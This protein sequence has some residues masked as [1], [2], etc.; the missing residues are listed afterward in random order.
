MVRT[1]TSSWPSDD[2][3]YA[4]RVPSGDS[5]GRSSGWLAVDQAQRRPRCGRPPVGPTCRATPLVVAG[6][7]VHAR[8]VATPD[9]IACIERPA[10]ERL[11]RALR[12]VEQPQAAA[13]RRR[14]GART[15]LTRVRTERRAPRAA[16]GVFGDAHRRPRRHA[17]AMERQAAQATDR[18]HGDV[19]QLMP[20]GMHG[21]VAQVEFAGRQHELRRA[22][23]RALRGERQLP[24]IEVVVHPHVVGGAPI[25]RERHVE[26]PGAGL[27]HPCRAPRCRGRPS[28]TPRC[29][30]AGSRRRDDGR[31]ETR[32]GGRGC[33]RGA[34]PA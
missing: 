11:H 19:G 4:R 22:R 13:A 5:R 28:R 16:D 26:R 9:R 6:L 27:E 25:R 15:R 34:S 32:S 31:R 7:E 20:L 12:Q 2:R 14:S 3:V 23:G 18:G 30:G 24:Q 10:G 33:P 21:D 29:R 8:A 17:I 1:Q